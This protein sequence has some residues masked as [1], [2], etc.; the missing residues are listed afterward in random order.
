MNATSREKAFTWSSITLIFA[1]SAVRTSLDLGQ[2]YDLDEDTATRVR[3]RIM[4]KADLSAESEICWMRVLN[5]EA[6]FLTRVAAKSID[7]IFRSESS[8]SA[9]ISGPQAECYS[10]DSGSMIMYVHEYVSARS[11]P[12]GGGDNPYPMP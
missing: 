1:I 4:W 3:I 2:S 9:T 12:Q 11:T 7:M 5:D 8:D 10:V 6:F